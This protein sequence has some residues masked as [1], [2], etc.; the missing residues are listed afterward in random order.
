MLDYWG[1]VNCMPVVPLVTNLSVCQTL[2]QNIE[3]EE[4][5]VLTWHDENLKVKVKFEDYRK[6]HRVITGMNENTI[7]GMLESGQTEPLY[8][9]I[10]DT[11]Y[12]EGFREF[13]STTIV[14]L[15][16]KYTKLYNK[17]HEVY[18]TAAAN[19]RK[20]YAEH[21]TKHPTV[22]PILFGI[23]DKKDIKPII[24][25]IISKTKGDNDLYDKL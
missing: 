24:W 19:S 4:G 20:E 3:N 16:T 14:T 23:L 6:L 9:I 22:A 1:G 13:L 7:Q 10:A 2:E 12:P 8:T 11:D 17:A 18:S 5:Y 15:M 25:K 21:F